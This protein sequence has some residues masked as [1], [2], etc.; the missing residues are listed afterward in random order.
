M[1][2]EEQRDHC[3]KLNKLTWELAIWIPDEKIVKNIM[4]KLSHNSKKDIK[5]IILSIRKQVHKSDVEELKW[6]DLVY[7]K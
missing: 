3:E 6:Q 1:T 4:D 2:K 5:E 7:F